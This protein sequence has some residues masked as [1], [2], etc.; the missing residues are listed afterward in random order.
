MVRTIRVSQTE[1]KAKVTYTI[2]QKVYPLMAGTKTE[3]KA[4]ME[5][6]PKKGISVSESPLKFVEKT[7]VTI[8]VVQFFVHSYYLVNVLLV[9]R[10]VYGQ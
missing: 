10:W 4:M 6:D 1:T 9:L 7:I 8:F 5:K 3:E 2:V